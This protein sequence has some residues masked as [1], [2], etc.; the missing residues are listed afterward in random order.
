MK[1]VLITG[2]NGQLGTALR[3]EADG[4]GEFHCTY[5]DIND[6]DLTNDDNVHH[7]FS[8]SGFDYIVNCAA[9]TAVDKAENNVEEAYTVNEK[10]PRLLATECSRVGTRL[11]HISTDY[12]YDGS[13]NTPHREEDTPR[14]E[15]VYGQSKLAG[16]RALWDNPFCTVIRT[17]WL[18]SEFGNNF[19]KSMLNL[20]K[21]RQELGVVFDQIGSPTYAG[22]LANAIFR[23]LSYSEKNS[24]KPG[25]Y[26][27][28]N[29]GICSWYDFAVEIMKGSGS[30]CR[31]RPIRT[32]EYPLPAVRPAYSVMDKSKIKRNF[33]IEIPYWRESLQTAIRNTVRQ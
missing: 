12:V 14:P 10:I 28:S 4:F 8:R 11:I 24:F 27:Y 13:K 2:S 21:T 29:E 22:D 33:E 15:S 23:I 5:I 3:R 1:K 25:I 7:Y 26:N 17:S 9:Y 18:Y 31:V 6:L 30:T 16:E 20:S 19:L 32:Y